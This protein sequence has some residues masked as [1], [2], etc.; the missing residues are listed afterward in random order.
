MPGK[1]IDIPKCFLYDAMFVVDAKVKNWRDAVSKLPGMVL[2][3]HYDRELIKE[4]TAQLFVR[5]QA[6]GSSLGSIAVPHARSGGLATCHVAWVKPRQPIE[7]PG[8]G[9]RP[10]ELICSYFAPPNSDDFTLLEM[11]RILPLMQSHSRIEEWWPGDSM[12]EAQ[13]E[14]VVYGAY[15]SAKAS[16]QVPRVLPALLALCQGY[17][18]IEWFLGGSGE[19]LEAGSGQVR[20]D[21]AQREIIAA[22]CA[23]MDFQGAWSSIQLAQTWRHGLGVGSGESM[24]VIERAVGRELARGGAGAASEPLGAL[25]TWLRQDRPAPPGVVDE[26]WRSTSH[27]GE[28]L[29]VQLEHASIWSELAYKLRHDDLR[30]PAHLLGTLQQ[31]LVLGGDDSGE[32]WSDLDGYFRRDVAEDLWRARYR[33]AVLLATAFEREKSPARHVKGESP[34]VRGLREVLHAVWLHHFGIAEWVRRVIASVDLARGAHE[35]W[36]Q[37]LARGHEAALAGVEQTQQVM[38]ELRQA[39]CELADHFYDHC[40]D[41]WPERYATRVESKRAEKVT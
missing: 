23:G 15:H 4:L 1:P 19:A 29:R 7:W 24:E 30:S 22:K 27:C 5:E 28:L 6:S 25:F 2:G 8:T 17:L 26:A 39:W 35:Q 11:S 12:T 34:A 40:P 21:A 14:R 41:M 37:W 36:Y 16:L 33:S 3:K 13:L 18:A 38:S 20:Y 9:G 32:I 10:V 31:L